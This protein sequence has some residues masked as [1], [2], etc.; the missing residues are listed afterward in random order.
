MTCFPTPQS[1]RGGSLPKLSWADRDQ[2]WELMCRKDR[3]YKRN[4]DY[5]RRH[6]E[7][8]QRMRAILLDWLTEVCFILI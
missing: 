3:L 7:L 4:P 8:E 6:R 2:V 5:I 1:K